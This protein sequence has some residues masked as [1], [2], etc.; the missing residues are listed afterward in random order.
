MIRKDSNHGILKKKDNNLTATQACD[1]KN[2]ARHHVPYETL[3]RWWKHFELW[4]ETS[5]QTARRTSIRFGKDRLDPGIGERIIQLLEEDSSRYLD[6]IQDCL[7][8][9]FQV[10]YHTS[11]ISRYLNSPEVNFTLRVLQEKALQQS[12]YE[13]ALYRGT[14]STLSQGKDPSIFCFCDESAVGKNASRRRRGW[15]RRG[16]KAIKYAMFDEG[17]SGSRHAYTLIGL[18]DIN[19]FVPDA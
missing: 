19:G 11:T 16:E 9:E 14:M 15:V 8:N 12:F 5:F 1:K 4:G 13:Q 3:R 18:V 10:R 6:E 2:G 17:I 7:I